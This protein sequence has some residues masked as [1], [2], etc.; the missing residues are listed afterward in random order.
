[1]VNSMVFP[2]FSPY[3]FKIFFVSMYKI[4]WQKV[5]ERLLKLQTTLNIK[6]SRQFALSLDIKGKPGDP[7]YIKKAEKGAAL[8][9][10]YILAI[11]EKFNVNP[12]WLKYGQGEIFGKSPKY[13]P[14][15]KSGSVLMED[16]PNRSKE[17]ISQRL[18]QYGALLSVLVSELAA[19][20]VSIGGGKAEDELKKIY[21]AAESLKTGG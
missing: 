15:G 18:D 7:S 19:I 5:G 4:D 16:D 14:H 2:N 1:M 10:S 20:K 9:E 13:V 8:S 6:S 11:R 12:E 3:F 21:K 17:P